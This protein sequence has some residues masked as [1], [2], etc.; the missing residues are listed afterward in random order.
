MFKSESEN[1]FS[2]LS[3]VFLFG[4]ILPLIVQIFVYNDPHD[5][6]FRTTSAAGAIYIAAIVS[7]VTQ[8][9]LALLEYRSR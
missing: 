9:Y 8:S 7:S 1:H 5:E 2:R 6:N 3:F 4:H